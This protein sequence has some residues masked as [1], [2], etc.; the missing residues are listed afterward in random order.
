MMERQAQD[1]QEQDRQEKGIFGRLRL[2]AG[3]GGLLDRT[4]D[5][6]RMALLWEQIWPPLAALLTLFGLFLSVSWL[7]LWLW[8]P[9]IGRAIGVLLFGLA[10][11]AALWRL[12]RLR[13]P[14]EADAL[15]RIDRIS[16][17]LHRPATAISDQLAVTQSD[18]MSAALWQAHV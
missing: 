1:R 7:G 11:L 15:R 13:L 8:L 16:G 14:N 10:A 5:R 3:S 9:S 17:L 6:A 18:P 2:G 12:V 4:I